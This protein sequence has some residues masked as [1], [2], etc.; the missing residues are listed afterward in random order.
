[1]F[2]AIIWNVDPE[3][4]SIGSLS[5]RY[6]GL[7]F[8]MAFVTGYVIMQRYFRRDG[9][10]TKELDLLA[11]Y[12][13]FATL[14]GARLGHC[15]FY[16]PEYYLKN[17]IEI[18]MVWH[19]GLASHGA[20][21]AIILA[22]FL[23]SRKTKIPVLNILDRVVIVVALGGFFIRMG[24]LFNSEI[25]GHETT[26]PWGMVFIRAGEAVP[27]HPTQIYEA[28]AAL[29]IFIGLHRLFIKKYKQ[30]SEGFIF[31]LFLIALFTF[32]FFIEFIKEPQV[33][34]EATMMLNMGQWLSLPFVLFGLL[35]LVY[36][37]QRDGY[38]IKKDRA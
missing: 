32:R 12:V 29:I 14:I 10:G 18:L 15:L 1:M 25:Y 3:I 30:L 16:E 9:L 28:V 5:V 24:N 8:A 6:Y 20:A 23:Y 22:L 4:F 11:T 36:F 38:L 27:K 35:L 7:L 31:S 34:R 33:A 19:G 26:L 21:I 2:N 17:P 37:Y 13:F